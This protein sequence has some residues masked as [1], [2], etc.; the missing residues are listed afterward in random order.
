MSDKCVIIL[1]YCRDLYDHESDVQHELLYGTWEGEVNKARHDYINHYT[2]MINKK[3]CAWCKFME[4]NITTGTTK[5]W[6]EKTT[7]QLKRVELNLEAK[8]AKMKIPRKMSASEMLQQL[9]T[10]G[11]PP[12]AGFFTT[13]TISGSQFEEPVPSTNG[14]NW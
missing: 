12:S 10:F 14:G 1:T 4:V 7:P 11:A 9:N 3:S 2:A 8:A 6:F 13:T 5:V